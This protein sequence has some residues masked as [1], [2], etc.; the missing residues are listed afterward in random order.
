MFLYNAETSSRAGIFC[1]NLIREILIADN[2]VVSIFDGF[3][4]ER[5]TNK[6]T[7]DICRFDR[8][9]RRA[10]YETLNKFSR[11]IRG[12]CT[13]NYRSF[14]QPTKIRSI[15]NRNAKISSKVYRPGGL[16]RI[17]EYF[18]FNVGHTHYVKVNG[19]HITR[20]NVTPANSIIKVS[21]LSIP[22]A[23]NRFYHD[24]ARRVPRRR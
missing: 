18:V 23:A 19:N 20:N 3:A 15:A 6:Q 11:W 21:Q 2:R 5:N 24:V 4:T 16:Y 10:M 22:F 12:I 14:E 8:E 7:V 13:R 1:S 17:V 9:N